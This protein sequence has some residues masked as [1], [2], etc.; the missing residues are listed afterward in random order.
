M[1]L[2]VRTI[3]HDID[4]FQH[5]QVSR[6]N[7]KL[8]LFISYLSTKYHHCFTFMV[9]NYTQSPYVEV[10]PTLHI[11]KNCLLLEDKLIITSQATSLISS[12]IILTLV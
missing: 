2:F 6:K 1:I 9:S 5:T 11:A 12:N 10:F 8:G 4:S 7:C 3:C